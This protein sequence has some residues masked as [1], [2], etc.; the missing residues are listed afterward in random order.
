MV[1]S[2]GLGMYLVCFRWTWVWK[3][4]INSGCLEAPEA[5]LTERK[6]AWL[7]MVIGT[8]WQVLYFACAWSR[9]SPLGSLTACQRGIWHAHAPVTPGSHHFESALHSGK[10]RRQCMAS[11][12]HAEVFQQ[13]HSRRCLLSR[14]KTPDPHEASAFSAGQVGGGMLCS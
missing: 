4:L 5:Q 3:T 12:T 2:A 1:G 8:W 9:A 13:A 6:E 10:A 7:R 14:L 11:F